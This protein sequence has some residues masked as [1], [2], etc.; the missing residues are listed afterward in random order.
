MNLGQSETTPASDQVSVSEPNEVQTRWAQRNVP[1]QTKYAYDKSVGLEFEAGTTGAM[2]GDAGHGAATYLRFE[3]RDDLDV[4][5]LGSVEFR[6]QDNKAELLFY[7]DWEIDAVKNALRHMLATL[8]DQTAPENLQGIV[9]SWNS[10]KRVGTIA[11]SGDASQR[12]FIF[13]SRI[14]SG[15]EPQLGSLVTFE[16]SPYPPQ[17]NKLPLADHIH[18][19]DAQKAGTKAGV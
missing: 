13:G 6:V 8:E 17:P 11:L 2:G 1:I 4:W 12:F 18:V 16:R 10:V 14:L 7:G 9:T 3:V 19:Q 15:P 5:S